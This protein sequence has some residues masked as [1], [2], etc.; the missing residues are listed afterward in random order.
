VQLWVDG[1]PVSPTV[2]KTGSTTKVYYTPPSAF[3]ANATHTAQLTFGDRTLNWSF[4]VENHKN[5]TF[6]IE[7]EDFNFGGGQ[8]MAAASTM[9]YYGG[10]YAG[11]SAVPGVDYSR[12]SQDSGQWYRL[13]PT[14]GQV[15][16]PFQV[17][18]DLDRGV[19]ELQA[20]HRIGWIGGGQW[21]NYTRTFPSNLYN[22]YVGMG[23]GDTAG[24]TAHA[25]YGVLQMVD[26]PTTPTVTNSLGL[27]D[28]FSTGNYGQNGGVGQAGGQGLVPMT[29]NNGNMLAITLSGTQTLRFYLPSGSTN[30]TITINGNTFIPHGGS[31]DY[32]F[33]MFVPAAQVVNR[34]PISIGLV[35]GKPTITYGGT[36]LFSPNAAGPYNPVSGAVSPYTVPAGAAAGFYRSQQ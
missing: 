5:A 25:R 27:F 21:Y 34:P 2:T 20:N 15:A 12:A 32:D 31:G 17:N 13:F 23:Q 33:L 18:H 16:V 35:G 14:A 29:D 22:V 30:E 26:S 36:L 7:A 8:T 1:S 28:G 24:A 19:N 4:Q 3:T 9:P 11:Q 10:A 6:F